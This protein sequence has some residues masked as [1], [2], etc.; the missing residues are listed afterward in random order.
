MSGKER[1]RLAVIR[2]VADR[3]L[4]QARAAELWA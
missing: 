1:N 4:R 2:R 3:E